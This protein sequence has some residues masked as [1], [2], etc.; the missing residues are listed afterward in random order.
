ME[1]SDFQEKINEMIPKLAVLI[2][3]KSDQLF[4]CGG[5]DTTEYE[6]DFILP[7]IV[8]HA[9]LFEASWQYKPTDPESIRRANNL[10]HF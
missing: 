3:E 4:D 5:I 10:N 7:R 9:A 1:K 2:K 6:N 8:M